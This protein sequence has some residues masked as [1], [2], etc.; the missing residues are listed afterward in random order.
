[1]SGYV[2]ARL[3][4]ASGDW[5]L[6]LRDGA[7]GRAMTASQGFRSSEVASTWVHAGDRIVA[8]GCR[9]S[10]RSRTAAVSFRLA[11]VAA[12]KAA[13]IPELVRVYGD[14]RKLDGLD[15]LKGFDVTEGRRSNYADVVV[16]GAQ[17][18]AELHAMK[19]RYDVRFANLDDAYLSARRADARYTKRVNGRSPLP[20]GR[21]DYR[22][23]ADIQDELK[24]IAGAHADTVKPLVIGKTFQG[25]EIQGLEIANDV[26][27]DDGRPIFF[28]MALHHAREWPS[29][30]AAMEFAHML[31]EETS[32]PRIAKIM[33][34][35]RVVVVPL[36]NADGFVSS[37]G[38]FDPGDSVTDQD[39]NATLVEAVA[40][41]GGDFAYRRK[42]CDGAVPS[43]DFP[44]ELQWGVDNNRNYGN[45]WGGN[46]ASQDPNSQAYKGTGPRSEPETQAVWNFARTHNVT[47]LITLHNVAALV[48]RPPGLHDG[49]KAP[50]E[51]RMK[52]IG[53]AMA[54]A[55]GYTSEFGFQLYDTAGTTEDD[56]YAATG[57]YGYTIEIGPE[58]GN[59]HMPYETGVVNEWTGNNKKA[60]GRGGL[61]EALL[62]GAE[63]AGNPSDHATLRGHAPAGSVLELTKSFDTKTSDYCP[64]GIDP[65]LG[66][67][68]LP[69][70]VHCPTGNSPALTLKDK[71]DLKTVVPA[72]GTFDWS[73]NQ[74]TRPFVGGGSVK[75]TLAD[76]PYK[77]GKSLDG[78]SGE[79]TMR[80]DVAPEDSPNA[81]KVSLDADVPAEDYDLYVYTVNPDGSRGEQVASSATGSASEMA[82]MK[83]PDPGTYE[84]EVDDYTA[85]TDSWKLSTAYYEIKRETT[86]GTKEAYTL[87]CADAQGNVLETR[88]LVI[89]RSQTV[90]L[91]LCGATGPLGD[92]ATTPGTA[93]SKAKAKP[94][95][96]A[97]SKKAKARARC[98]AKAKRIKSSRKRKAALR[99][100]DKPTKKKAAK[101]HAAKKKK[102]R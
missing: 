100:C 91:N 9:R 82:E 86:T 94:K 92:E 10:G 41:T 74:S 16:D 89:D 88:D 71:L 102:R 15:Q 70:P 57:A 40:P 18:L 101:K 4:A 80:F 97:S 31:T 32:D 28:L 73:L 5:D 99:R 64:M 34:T 42:N 83:T 39:S 24:K 56:T 1:M 38:A 46:G 67:D 17:Q 19:L 29:A 44:C 45:L 43:G 61:R 96:K 72:S 87:T 27:A 54:G 13:G 11:D 37:R 6:L 75:E 78:S 90:A 93:P 81:V 35:E 7:S 50:D 52:Q 68:A 60:S 8:V 36:V 62:I 47:N 25:R 77:Q 95:T 14:P 12:P 65:A 55:T 84:A 20:S 3:Q 63:A 2:T 33:S 23:Y 49:G 79:H 76:K 51:Q 85:V 59:F 69:D 30:E 98:R 22:T 53:D 26:K 58:G 66:S 21:T 48:L